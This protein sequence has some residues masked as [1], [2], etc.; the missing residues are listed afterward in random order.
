MESRFAIG[1][2]KDLAIFAFSGG[3]SILSVRTFAGRQARPGWAR[4]FFV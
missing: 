1:S 4:R 3:G 2:G